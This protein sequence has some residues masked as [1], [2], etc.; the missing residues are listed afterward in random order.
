[1]L[2]IKSINTKISLIFII[3]ILVVVLASNAII[4][5]VVSRIMIEQAISRQS[6][7]ISH[8]TTIFNNLLVNINH[9]V[10]NLCRD[11][12]IV[13]VL[14]SK[15]EKPIDY[16]SGR[17]IIERQFR[18]HFIQLM[19]FA[20]YKYT[21]FFIQDNFPISKGFFPRSLDQTE[22]IRNGVFTADYVKDQPWYIETV[23]KNGSFHCF[24]LDNDNKNI[25]ISR[26]VK[27]PYINTYGYEKIGVLLLC[28]DINEFSSHLDISRL[29]KNTQI[30]LLD[31][32][33][34][35][36][37]NYQYE[38]L[39]EDVG[40]SPLFSYLDSNSKKIARIVEFNNEKFVTA[41]SDLKW[42]WGLIS[43]IPYSDILS[44]LDTV[45]GI[46]SII[47]IIA[48]ALGTTITI[49]VS[50]SISR[51]IKH[52]AMTMNNIRSETAIRTRLDYRNN[53]EV[54]VLYDSFNKM[55]D[56]IDSLVAEAYESAIKQKITELKALQAQINPHFV[57][58]T[59]DSVNWI[60]LCN[61]QDIIVS[62][63][64]S[65]SSILRYSIKEPNRL[66]S[67]SEELEHVRNYLNIQTLRYENSF[68][69]EYNIDQEF[70]GLKL[71]K[72]LIQPL[73]ENSIIH[74]ILTVKEKGRIVISLDCSNETVLIS[75]SDNG[76]N[77]DPDALNDYLL[78]KKA[79]LR[80]SDG[81]GIRS[82]HERIKINF[83]DAYG[84]SY[85]TVQ[86][87]GL[88]AEI[89]IPRKFD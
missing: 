62:M 79:F 34:K 67:L 11:G 74:G 13:S 77:A 23:S 87:G 44:V 89:R 80:E 9:A 2:I 40:K 37:F 14:N 33:K 22:N 75:V 3:V 41:I 35:M 53:D 54:K 42:G 21:F 26:L 20:P 84:L 5:S 76:I 30:A 66:A 64:S 1:M 82:V 31:E 85:K 25:Y 46:I 73:V 16:Y 36:I 8:N 72:F 83:G 15:A 17:D 48:L 81:F 70:M 71:P 49:G 4:Y 65:L 28:M 68:T 52:L 24:Y 12:A 51:P 19:D 86:G 88:V 18:Q 10:A 59:L 7:L 45:T 69:V 57:Y 60:A 47:T 29:T 55:M 56:R 78:G 61:N 39:G 38:L 63:I 43:A 58:N 27:N 50:R 6:N 32:N